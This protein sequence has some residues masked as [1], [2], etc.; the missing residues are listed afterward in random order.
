LGLSDRGRIEPGLRADLC[1]VDPRT[2]VVEAT[3]SAGRVSHLVG[4]A[5]TRLLSAALEARRAA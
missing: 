3:L 5:A 1:V 4:G 2:R